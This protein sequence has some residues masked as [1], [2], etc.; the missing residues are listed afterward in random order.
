VGDQVLVEKAGEIIPQV[1][2][3]VNPNASNRSAVFKMPEHCPACD[4]KLVKY[5]GEVAWRCINPACPPQVSA[6][7]IH[8]AS[9][10]AMDI[11]G[12]GE[13]VIQQLVDEGLITT[14]ADLYDLTVD[15]ILPLER[16]GEKSAKN[17]IDA[18][19]KSKEQPFEKV[20]FGLGIRFVGSTVAKDLARAFGSIDNII[21]ATPE[22][23]SAVDSIGP[24]IA[25]S[26]HDFFKS[27][28]NLNIVGKLRSAGLQFESQEQPLTNGVFKGK[29]FVLTG[30]LPTLGR[31]EASEI[32]ENHGGRTS[33]SVSKKTDFVLA[34]ESAGSKLEKAKKLDVTILS[35]DD[36]F[37]M[38]NTAP[39]D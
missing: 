14:Y 27:E 5:E 15:Q 23:L 28:Q 39:K 19:N 10:T 31:K 7:I 11:D 13:A 35:E 26:V 18:L 21:S 3:V 22:E 24:K 30:T 37:S 16:M 4:S 2:S 36:L 1:V 34:G 20:L 6:R 12:L 25:D 17:L 38:I 32:I 9:R 33:S 29:T 8:F